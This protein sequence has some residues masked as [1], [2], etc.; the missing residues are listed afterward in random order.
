MLWVSLSVLLSTVACAGCCPHPV[1]RDA[2]W[3]TTVHDVGGDSLSLM[4]KYLVKERYWRS[5]VL[6]KAAST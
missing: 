4:T 3:R 2:R 1:P 5:G 6:P